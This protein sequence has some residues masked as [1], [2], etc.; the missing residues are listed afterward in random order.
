MKLIDTHSIYKLTADT[1]E[2]LFKEFLDDAIDYYDKNI[3]KLVEAFNKEDLELI[4]QICHMLF[5]V[6]GQV[7][8]KKASFICKQI[9]QSLNN[10]GLKLTNEELDHLQETVAKSKLELVSLGYL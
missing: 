1:S 3:G 10:G 9:E 8:M 4:R 5:G 6:L 2:E 7:G